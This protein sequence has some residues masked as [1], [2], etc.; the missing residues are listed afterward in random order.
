MEWKYTH[1]TKEERVCILKTNV[2]PQ[3]SDHF[4]HLLQSYVSRSKHPDFIN[5]PPPKR[6]FLRVTALP[7]KKTISISR[8]RNGS[9]KRRQSERRRPNLRSRRKRGPC[10]RSWR[11]CSS[12]PSILGGGSL[13]CRRR[14]ST[15]N[16]RY[17]SRILPKLSR[18]VCNLC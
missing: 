13:P 8:R 18:I 12:W 5:P 2:R 3:L 16:A 10:P 17:L 9:V 14:W 6:I 7:Q 11:S 4:P 1:D 15:T